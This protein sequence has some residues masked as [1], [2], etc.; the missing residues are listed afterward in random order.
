MFLYGQK[1]VQAALEAGV[2]P[3]HRIHLLQNRSFP[4]IESLAKALGI[5]EERCGPDRLRELIKGKGPVGRDQGV[6]LRCGERPIEMKTTLETVAVSLATPLQ[7]SKDQL[8]SMDSDDV[9]AALTSW[10]QE[11]EEEEE[12]DHTNSES[13]RS[14]IVATHG[15]PVVVLAYRVHD[16]MNLG[17]ICRAAW[18][19]GAREVILSE[20]RS[21]T[22]SSVT[23][24]VSSASAGAAELVNLSQTISTA[25]L[26]REARASGWTVA[27]ASMA[28]PPG[29]Q[30]QSPSALRD[31]RGGLVLV[32][33]NENDGLPA[34]IIALCSF[35]V[36]IAPGAQGTG[37]V[38]S[39]NV[40]AATAI[41]LHEATQANRRN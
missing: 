7:A 25:E 12:E 26:L 6:V 36:S 4:L 30:V 11:E 29:T 19:L 18:F 41:L 10:L 28:G 38:D 9:K 13:T 37:S 16:V 2:R 27:A 32:V 24:A 20:P 35:A 8:G 14:E 5:R 15:S 21:G 31:H 22:L 33:G 40:G 17:A 3:M 39:L 1:S 34:N 23:A